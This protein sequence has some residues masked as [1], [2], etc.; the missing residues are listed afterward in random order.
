MIA[1]PFIWLLLK[2]LILYSS[3]ALF[4]I[5]VINKPMKDKFERTEAAEHFAAHLK[6]SDVSGD[7]NNNIFKGRGVIM[8]K[9]TWR[10]A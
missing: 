4:L 3:L 9:K 1:R 7:Q 6:A 10:K 5:S 2:P 8:W